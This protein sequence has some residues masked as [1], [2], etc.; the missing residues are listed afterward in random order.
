MVYV[1]SLNR[2][3]F[4][5]F[6]LI[7]EFPSTSGFPPKELFKVNSC[8]STLHIWWWQVAKWPASCW[9]AGWHFQTLARACPSLH[10]CEASW[11]WWVFT[12]FYQMDPNG[13]VW[14]CCAPNSLKLYWFL[15]T[16]FPLEGIPMSS[17]VLDTLK[18]LQVWSMFFTWGSFCSVLG[19]ISAPGSAF[20]FPSRDWPWGHGQS[21]TDHFRTA[22]SLQS[23][24]HD[25]DSPTMS[26]R[27]TLRQDRQGIVI[28]E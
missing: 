25:R 2:C 27:K 20:P 28:P 16:S 15:I 1:R 9:L 22:G 4:L 10:I 18:R 14:T 11:V 8:K 21:A 23:W 6:L 5:S 26:N 12:C 13:F 19:R 7:A 24:A 3:S 17:P